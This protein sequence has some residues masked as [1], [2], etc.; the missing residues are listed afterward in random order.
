MNNNTHTKLNNRTVGIT[1]QHGL[2][3]Q[4]V[5]RMRCEG[6]M[7]QIIKKT[8]HSYLISFQLWAT[9]TIHHPTTK[10]IILRGKKRHAWKKNEINV[11]IKSIQTFS[12]PA[13]SLTQLIPTIAA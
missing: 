7:F 8:D 2:G 11:I 9:S 6:S 5:R 1:S 13:N 12:I 4:M 10:N 3:G